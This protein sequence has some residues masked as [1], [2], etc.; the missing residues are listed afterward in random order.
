MQWFSSLSL[1]GQTAVVAGGGAAA[2]GASYSLGGDRIQRPA[3][4]ARRRLQSWIRRKLRGSTRQQITRLAGQLR[5][6]LRWSNIRAHLA[7]LRKY[8]T[9]AYWR[10]WID[11]RRELATREGLKTYLVG[12]YR[13]YRKRRWRG[14]LR[15]RLRSG[16]IAA[17]GGLIGTLS[18]GWLAAISGPAQ[19]ALSVVISETQRWIEDIVMDKFDALS[20]RYSG[21]V[22]QSSALVTAGRDRLWYLLTGERQESATR[23]VEAIAGKHT[24]ALEEVGIDSVDQLAA[25]DPDHIANTLELAPATTEAWTEQAAQ[26]DS[27]SQRSPILETRNAERIQQLW[28]SAGDQARQRLKRGQSALGQLTGRVKSRLEAPDRRLQSIDGIGPA[29]SERLIETGITTSTELAVCDPERLGSM[30]GVSPKRVHRWVAQ[31]QR[32][33]GWTATAGQQVATWAINGEAVMIGLQSSTS[34][35]L[36]QATVIDAWPFAEMDS[37]I[38]VVS[39]SAVGIESVE[40]LAAADADRLATAVDRHPD[41]VTEWIRAAQVSSDRPMTAE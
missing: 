26:V 1:V 39:L 8:F 25:A 10:E 17:S 32:T 36:E 16:V 2:A 27:K 30:I 21:F 11:S 6:Q 28:I 13:S 23:T 37:K 4:M 7:G 12:V 14:W 18:P 33:R 29:Y 40:Q 20:K 9:R 15:A 34:V 19:T 5:K 35:S 24:M 3:N 38:D 31:A 41:V 22:L